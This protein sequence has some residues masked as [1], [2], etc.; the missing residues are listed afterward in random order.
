MAIVQLSGH[1]RNAAADSSREAKERAQFSG[2]ARKLTTI[3]FV[4]NLGI[5]HDALTELADVSL[6]LQKRICPCQMH[7]TF[8]CGK[9][10]Y[11]CTC[12]IILDLL[13]LR[14]NWQQ[15]LVSFR[16]LP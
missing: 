12:R 2:L 3:Q 10:V 7:T 16:A 9:Y 13:H 5:M 8:W 15:L 6:M 1:V 14:Q 4:Q 11:L